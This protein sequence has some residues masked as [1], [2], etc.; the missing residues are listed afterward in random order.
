MDRNDII[1]A[2]DKLKILAFDKSVNPT[3]PYYQMAIDQI[4]CELSRECNTLELKRFL[5]SSKSTIHALQIAEDTI[6]KII[7]N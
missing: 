3:C 5:D 6:N 1:F 4:V 2:I 7:G